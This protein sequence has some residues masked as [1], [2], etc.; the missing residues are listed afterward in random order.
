MPTLRRS[1]SRTPSS[2]TLRLRGLVVAVVLA[3]FGTFLYQ[4]TN[5]AYD[6]EFKLT[7]LANTIGEGLAPGAEVKFHGMA[8]GSVKDLQTIGYNKQ[9]MTV[10]LEPRQAR[11]LTQDTVARFTSSNLF[12]TTEVELVSDGKGAPLRSN[13][14]LTV[15]ADSQAASITELL[16][17]AQRLARILDTPELNHVIDVLRR[18]SDLVEPA[19]KAVLDLTK[20]LAD[21]QALV[22]SQSLSVFAPLLNGV[23]R[24]VPVLD[25]TPDLVDAMNFLLAPGG[26]ERT[27]LVM[28]Q[29]GQLL[30]DVGQILVRNNPWLTHLVAGIMNVA[31][32]GAYAAGSMAPAYDRLS[33]LIDRTSTA[34]PVIDGQ[35]RMRT[36]VILDPPPGDASPGP[37]PGP[38]PGS[39][40]GPRPGPGPG[41]GR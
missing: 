20:T 32:P 8:I 19:L 40:F 22:I 39:A 7:V 23:N 36:E 28:R 41:G 5:G 17:E 16:R 12:G 37:G 15:R 31:V 25:Q 34:L 14:T 13:E 21:S 26:T 1:T 29:T 9:R 18:H 10:E 27:N 6:D 4:A 38:S 35:V 2:R 3:L 33:G 24:V 11:V 30:A